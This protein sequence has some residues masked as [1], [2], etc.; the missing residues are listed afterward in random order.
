MVF[1]NFT[2]GLAKTNKYTKWYY[3]I[4]S[5]SLHRSSSKKE[6]KEKLGYVECH[7][8]LPNSFKLGGD[9]DK[10]NIAFL[11]AREHM[12]C[13]WLLIKMFSNSNY[14]YSMMRAFHSMIFQNNGGRNKRCFP[15]HYDRARKY[16]S[17]ANKQV[18]GENCSGFD[19]RKI[20]L[21]NNLTREE[22]KILLT[23]YC[24]KDFSCVH[25][26][27]LLNTSATAIHNWLKHFGLS[28]RYFMR[29][30]E[31]LKKLTESMCILEISEKY[32]VTPQGLVWNCKKFDIEFIYR[33]FVKYPRKMVPT[34]PKTG[35]FMRTNY[36]TV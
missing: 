24:N 2:C 1:L 10:N 20:D 7:H 36:E 33:D 9:K 29:N 22:F 14:R 28:R 15:K 4:I 31:E 30:K 5:N 3:S 12:I 17:E 32:K 6:A 26:S 18:R 19:R 8:I 27:K 23:D 11:T 35:K 25:I 34:D 21:T 16:V 13:H